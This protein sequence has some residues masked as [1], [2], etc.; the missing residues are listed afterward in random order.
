MTTRIGATNTLST[1]LPVA[2]LGA[3]AVAAGTVVA[4]RGGGAA[5]MGRLLQ[6]GGLAAL[7]AALLTG[8]ARTPGVAPTPATGPTPTPTPP[9]PAPVPEPEPGPGPTP[10]G[11][12]G[13]DLRIAQL[14]A[15][16]FFDTVDQ[17]RVQDDVLTPEQ[18]S[19][20]LAKL[21]LAIR[22]VMAGPDII[23]ME[24]VENE[25]VLRDLAARPELAALGYRPL[26]VEGADPRGI[27][28]GYLYRPARVG[29]VSSAQ[30]N[31]TFTSPTGRAVKLFTRPPLVATFRP[32][33]QG[34][35][36]DATGGADITLV[37]NHF[38]SKLQGADGALKRL[39]QATFVA[40]IADGKA[41]VANLDPARTIVLGDFNEGV[42]EPGYRVLTGQDGGGT[43]RTNV[44]DR[45]PEADRYSYRSG[46]T[47]TL[48]DHVLLTP[49]LDAA[50]SAV[51][52]PHI[53]SD[54]SETRATDPTTPE[55]VSDHDPVLVDL[56]V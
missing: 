49:T 29:L 56:H 21:S 8:C 43:A 47:R 41:G 5:T 50:V 36:A 39:R 35:A 14:N 7:G 52:I 19:T 27:D 18:Y 23:A 12:Q 44:A 4:R 30:L 55:R 53:D 37:A 17:P 2:G 51:H 38:T 1:V 13:S 26:L 34:G 54:P 45:L 25:G 48:L 3:V 9:R 22:D 6:V 10:P 20:K 32:V 24:E 11:Q 42:G 16:N 33:G 28:V 40:S 31:T 46:R 15:H